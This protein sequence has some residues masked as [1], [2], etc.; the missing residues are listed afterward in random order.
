MGYR[1]LN[2]KLYSVGNIPHD[3]NSNCKLNN[4]VQNNVNFNEILNSKI[5]NEESFVISKHALKR[6]QER[7]IKLNKIDMKKINKAINS[8]VKKGSKDCLILYKDLA[9]VTS[10]KNRTVITA[11]NRDEAKENVF[12]N[13]DST[14]IL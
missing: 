9:L 14:I 10:I 13:I 6:M 4:K 1:Y 5:N 2:G 12:T 7:N 3:I 11:L 8:A